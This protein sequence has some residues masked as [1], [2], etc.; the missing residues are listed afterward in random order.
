MRRDWEG[1]TITMD[2]KVLVLGAGGLGCEVVKNLAVLKVREIHVVDL[3]TIELTNLNRQ[4]LF[5]DQDIGRYKAQVAAEYI[6]RWSEH[7]QISCTRA[8]AHCMDLLSLGSD[9]YEQFDFVISGLDAVQPRRF[10]NQLLVQ[11]TRNSNFEICIPLIDGGTEGLQGHVKTIIPGITACWECSIETLP[12]QQ[13]R[14]PMCTIANSPRN[15]EHVVEYVV[16][17][18]MAGEELDTK[19]LLQLCRDRALQFGIPADTLTESYAVGVA[20][21]IVP[22]VSSTNA[23]VAAICCNEMVKIYNDSVDF[24]TLKNFKTVSGINGLYINSFKFARLD[25]CPVCSGF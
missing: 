20:K 13:T 22:S 16:T 19:R 9:F 15:L 6:N 14:H 25:T 8:I 17:V 10:V 5:K 24:N 7:Q 3:D 1:A 12:Q 18:Q 11:L 23:L 4:F 2:V 21:R